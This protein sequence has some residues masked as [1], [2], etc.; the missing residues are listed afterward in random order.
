MLTAARPADPEQLW[1]QARTDF[2]EYRFE[3]AI[4]QAQQ[5]LD[6]PR[7]NKQND[8]AC[9]QLIAKAQQGQEMLA[10]VEDLTILDSVKTT[11]EKLLSAYTLPRDI[12]RLSMSAD[13]MITFTTGRGDKSILAQRSDR[14]TDIYRQ[15][16]NSEP[17]QLSN[18]INSAYNENFPFEM[19]DG[20]TLY[21][22][23]DNPTSLGGYDIYMTRYNNE[24]FDYTRPVNVGMPFNSIYNDYMLAID[25]LQGIGWFATDRFQH[26]DTIV[27][28]KFRSNEVKKMLPDVFEPTLRA[29]TAQLKRY[30]LGTERRS[31]KQNTRTDSKYTDMNFVVNDTIIYTAI[32]QF[33]DSAA[34]R[35]YEQTEELRRDLQ[36]RSVIVD[37]KKREF[38]Y[39]DNADD[40]AVL[41]REILEDEDYLLRTG[42]QI[43]KNTAEI[44]KLEI[45]AL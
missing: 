4:D 31:D 22:A 37:G 16:T 17:E 3:E 7:H 32:E 44:R 38:V 26:G 6:H 33:R 21:F 43:K 13:G 2:R 23:S 1:R 27:V 36:L 20:V 9:E 29:E 11:K 24:T 28:Y 42:E 40:R 14:Q 15:Y 18:A 39:T 30:T 5:Y 8:K 25:E 34:R 12:A 19:A 10:S 45:K 35:L 41:R